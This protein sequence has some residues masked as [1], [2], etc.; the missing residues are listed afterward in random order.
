[1]TKKNTRHIYFALDSDVLRNL[2]NIDEYI[3]NHPDYSK[4]EIKKAIMT[5]FTNSPML[6][7]LNVYLSLLELIK[8]ED[9]EIRLMVTTTPFKE[10][11]AIPNV[12]RFIKKYCYVPNINILTNDECNKEIRRLAKAYC[13][14][15]EKDG[16]TF[17]P[18]MQAKY[19][20]YV[21][22]KI[23]SNDAYVMAEATYYGASLLTEN[24][25]DLIEKQSQFKNLEKG[26]FQ[27]HQDNLRVRGIVDIN[28]LRGYGQEC[29]NS[30]YGEDS[31]KVPKPYSMSLLGHFIK[32]IEMNLEYYT[33][34]LDKK[35]I[36][37][38]DLEM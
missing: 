22:G 18:P 36:K 2:S 1:M 29:S 7:N 4:N 37:F 38:S 30:K 32:K 15:F 34:T 13:E 21:G 12:A 27:P 16:R 31:L 26:S 28:L 8:N 10:T 35:T 33:T 6:K 5:N 14:P 3:T 19:N 24:V 23:P 25:K 20:S 17:A 11:Q 9:S